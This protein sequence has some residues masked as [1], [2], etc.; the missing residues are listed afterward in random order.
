MLA[1]INRCEETKTYE[2]ILEILAIAI[3]SY[4]R[5]GNEQLIPHIQSID[6]FAERIK[7]RLATHDFVEE[8]ART[9]FVEKTLHDKNRT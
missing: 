1:S 6:S 5:T 3:R 4:E 2:D 8:D 9:A 7:T